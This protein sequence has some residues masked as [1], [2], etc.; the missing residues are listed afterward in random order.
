MKNKWHK[1]EPH[2][3]L[4]D[5]VM[6]SEDHVSRVKWSLARVEEVHPR[7]DGLVRTATVRKGNNVL[8]R[9][10]QRLLETASASPQGIPED[11]PVHGGEKLKRVNS[12]TVPVTK[13]KHNVVL[14]NRGQGGENGIDR[15]TCTS[16]LSKIQT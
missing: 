14:S 3:L 9:S 6:V 10:V 16:R 8:Q 4:I 2:L 12:K 15:Y 1:E 11:V 13:P 7:R 5:I